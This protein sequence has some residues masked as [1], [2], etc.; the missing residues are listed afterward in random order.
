M[1]GSN[2]FP[3]QRGRKPETGP[4]PLHECWIELGD[5][6]EGDAGGGDVVAAEQGAETNRVLAKQ[7][8]KMADQ[9]IK[10]QT[11]DVND[12]KTY[13]NL[14]K[15]VPSYLLTPI[16]VDINNYQKELVDTGY[17]K[18]EDLQ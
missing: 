6:V 17:I 10:G 3:P 5:L 4:L 14:V 18:A 8:A 12:T 2:C 15:V 9:A 13:D 11:V 7:A 16:S 1:V